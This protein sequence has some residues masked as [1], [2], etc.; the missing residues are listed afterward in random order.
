[1]T[2]PKSRLWQLLRRLIIQIE[3][4]LSRGIS[5]EWRGVFTFGMDQSHFRKP[6]DNR[7]PIFC[8]RATA[9]ES[10]D[11]VANG[12]EDVQVNLENAALVN[13]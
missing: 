7:H 1:M 9:V 12:A 11:A 8:C 10:F 13:N 6:L 5:I 3:G 2:F 4:A